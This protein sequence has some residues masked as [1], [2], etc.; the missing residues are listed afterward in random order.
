MLDRSARYNSA[1]RCSQTRLLIAFSFAVIVH[2]AVGQ[3]R[4]CQD[5]EG[6]R[7]AGLAGNCCPSNNG[8]NLGC[9]DANT[10]VSPAPP[11][12]PAWPSCYTV[13]TN[14]CR[15][16]YDGECDDGGPG[17]EYFGHCDQGTD[18]HDCGGRCLASSACSP[19]RA[20]PSRRCTR[21]RAPSCWRAS[22]RRSC[23]FS[24]NTCASICP[25]F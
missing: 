2:G 7:S 23:S 22:R 25:C 16:S 18:C 20:S 12:P 13:C 19:S 8:I 4:L 21:S 10:V 24:A 3:S 15:F 17:S 14:K 11:L 1:M 9:C 5:H 6:C